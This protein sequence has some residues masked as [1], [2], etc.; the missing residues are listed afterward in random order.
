M[1]PIRPGIMV[2]AVGCEHHTMKPSAECVWTVVA[3]MMGCDPSRPVVAADVLA[4]LG[5]MD[6][7]M[8]DAGRDVPTEV[9]AR[10]RDVPD[11]SALDGPDVTDTPMTVDLGAALG[12]GPAT[13]DTS[14]PPS[15]DGRI[16][17]CGSEVQ[18][19]SACHL[20]TIDPDHCGA[21]RAGV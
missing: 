8:A 6:D 10:V 19:G 5:T 1:M 21:C 18:C 16:V 12:D 9:D 17:C 13:T 4:D 20:L 7:S 15:D 2:E 3:L 14:L 11:A